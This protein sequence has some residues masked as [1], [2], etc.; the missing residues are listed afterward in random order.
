MRRRCVILVL[1]AVF[2]LL[3]CNEENSQIAEDLY[4]KDIVDVKPDNIFE[5]NAIV[6][7][8][9]LAVTDDVYTAFIGTY[10]DP[11]F[12]KISA[13]TAFELRT[14]SEWKF[15]K[16]IVIDSVSMHL[17]FDLKSSMYDTLTKQNV[18]IYRL[19]KSLKGIKR[20]SDLGEDFKGQLLASKLVSSQTV[21]TTFNITR[22]SEGVITKRDTL[23][24][25]NIKFKFEDAFAKT[26]AE[27][28]ISDPSIY[29]SQDRFNEFFKG[30]YVES[31]GVLTSGNG[32]LLAFNLTGGKT[33]MNIYYHFKDDENDSEG[34]IIS[35]PKAYAFGFYV[36]KSSQRINTFKHTPKPSIVGS[37]ESIYLLG[38]AGLK[39]NVNFNEIVSI[40]EW[41]GKKNRLI[42]NAD[43]VFKIDEV[44]DMDKVPLP[45]KLI[46]AAYNKDGDLV[47]LPG[48]SVSR[49]FYGG[50]LDLENSEY[51]FNIAFLIQE[52][53]NYSEEEF[54]ELTKIDLSK[55]LA[56]YPENRRES[57][58]RVILDGES[59][60]LNITYTEL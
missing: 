38:G 21:D 20:F 41:T 60:K 11:I 44:V 18:N 40:K 16:E 15:D 51:K 13:G 25:G 48:Y 43:L 28:F 27:E 55:G 5:L 14:S 17:G 2:S 53:V 26:F 23:V 10:N 12:G 49:A 37:S 9:D 36:N 45:K 6:E 35:D 56:L 34:V 59:I 22:D 42:N 31:D 57:P 29:S 33:L 7:L 46:L 1:L 54:Y 19:N 50:A 32:G 47:A 3:S 58:R 24:N 52:I 39:A 30:L 4:S 8:D